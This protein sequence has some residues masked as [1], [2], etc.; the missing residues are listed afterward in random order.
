MAGLPLPLYD[1]V[2]VFYPNTPLTMSQ[3]VPLQCVFSSTPD[4][5]FTSF[6][7]LLKKFG[8]YGMSHGDSSLTCFDKWAFIRKYN[9]CGK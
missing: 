7:S 3:G 4:L 8:Q 2:P 6:F 9:E 5:P 1:I